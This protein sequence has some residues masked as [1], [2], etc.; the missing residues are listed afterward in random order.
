MQSESNDMYSIGE[1]SL[2]HNDAL[3][4]NQNARPYGGTAVYSRIDYYPGYPFWHNRNGIEVTVIRL[5]IVPHI[6]IIAIYRSPNVPMRQLCITLEDLLHEQTTEL[7]VFIG[8]FNVNW[9]NLSDRAPLYN[10]FV[11]DNQYRQLMS[12][13]T[14]D[15]KTCI[16]HIYTNLPQTIKT[17]VLE[18]YFSDHKAVY[19]LLTC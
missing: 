15:N 16:D 1:Y 4:S 10:L 19:A 13:Y 3:I 7:K 5:M 18:T 14:T 9:L 8:D 2:F 17:G 12:C 6:T 11:R